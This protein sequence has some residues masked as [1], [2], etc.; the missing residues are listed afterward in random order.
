MILQ[1]NDFGRSHL[2]EHHRVPDDDTDNIYNFTIYLLNF[3]IVTNCRVTE[4]CHGR[5]DNGCNQLIKRH[6]TRVIWS[7]CLNG[8]EKK[9]N[10]KRNICIYIP[11]LEVWSDE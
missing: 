8:M 5:T 9:Y 1:G 3:H 7:S 2:K 4:V 11:Y 10:E 6:D